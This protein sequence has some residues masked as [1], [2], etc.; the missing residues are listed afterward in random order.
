MW[1]SLNELVHQMESF[2]NLFLDASPGP[3]AEEPI[4]IVYKGEAKLG[5]NA[6]VHIEVAMWG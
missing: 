5:P 1:L 2:P 4:G 3:S 6:P